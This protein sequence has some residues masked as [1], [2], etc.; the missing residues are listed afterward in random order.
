MTT[1]DVTGHARAPVTSG[2]RPRLAVAATFPIHPPLGGGQ[3]RAAQLY[4]GLSEV[5]DIE[6]VTLVDAPARGGRTQVGP[7]L[8]E[9]R[10]PKSATHAE[11]ERLLER[12]AGTVV[13]DIAM[14]E[15]YRETP[16]YLAALD[17]ATAGACAVVACHPYVFP[18]IRE[19]TTIPV[20]YEAQDV[21]ASLKRYV[22]GA[23]REAQRLLA[24]AEAVERACCEQ[25]E[26]VWACS[27]EDRNELIE[28]YGVEPSRVLVVPNGVALDEVSYAPPPARLERKRRLRLEDRFLALFIASW[29]EPNLVAARELVQLAPHVPEIDVMIIGSVGLALTGWPLPANV[30]VTGTVC[31]EFKQTVLGIADAAL[32]P[33]R[34]GSGTNLKMLEYFGSGTPVIS[35][36]FGARGLGVRAG[37]HYIEAEG[38]GFATTLRRLRALNF[39]GSEPMVAAAR[40]HVEQTLSWQSI[41]AELLTCL[42]ARENSVSALAGRSALQ[43]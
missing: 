6:L 40:H 39:E 10:V 30:Q 11:R 33:V 42:R 22:L 23:S 35:T 9:H 13:T 21:E 18:A 32:N 8:W 3:V 1:A 28:S 25:A 14:T 4:R 38:R 20:W 31:T 7:A 27:E 36:A 19:V 24:R 26:L 37:E 2:L 5:F 34:T 16:D 12:D 41:A 43:P 15:L 29:H 17:R